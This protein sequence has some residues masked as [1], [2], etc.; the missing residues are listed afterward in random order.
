MTPVEQLV[1]LASTGQRPTFGG[2]SP[3]DQSALIAALVPTHRLFTASERALF[4]SFVLELG[5]SSLFQ[6][7]NYNET[8]IHRAPILD[9]GGVSAVPSDLLTWCGEGDGYHELQALLWNLPIVPAVSNF[10]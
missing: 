1:T 10:Q 3:E 4:D 2:L 6:I 8:A 7:E 5:E 9:N